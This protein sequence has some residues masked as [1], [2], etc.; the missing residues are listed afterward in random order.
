[1]KYIYDTMYE[2][3]NAMSREPVAYLYEL[4]LI[5]YIGSFRLYTHRLSTDKIIMQ[6]L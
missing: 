2:I 3:C 1:M 6:L 4:Y 5:H